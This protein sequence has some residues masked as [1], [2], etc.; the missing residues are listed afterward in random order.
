MSL[1]REQR[2]P[3]WPQTFDL[4]RAN[5][6]DD[7]LA[8]DLV[9]RVTEHPAAR[10]VD[11]GVTPLEVEQE[12]AVRRQLD[13]L[14]R[15]RVVL[16]QGDVDAVERRSD[17]GEHDQSCDRGRCREK[18]DLERWLAGASGG[19]DSCDGDAEQRRE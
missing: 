17:E 10:A 13:Q 6:L 7:R 19:G 18:G 5:R 12:D 15:P 8:D 2:L 1:T 9:A 3:G 16:L 11:V 4:V 14:A